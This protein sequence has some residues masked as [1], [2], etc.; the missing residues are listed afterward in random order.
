L[1]RYAR[2][3][4]PVRPGDDE[5]R[6]QSLLDVE[7]DLDAAVL[8]RLGT[9]LG[10]H[11]A[12]PH[13]CFFGLLDGYAQ[14]HGSPAVSLFT[15]GGGGRAGHEPEP[16]LPPAFPPPVL[17]GPRVSLPA[18]DYL[19]FRGP[20]SLAGEW[21]GMDLAPGQP[22]AINSPNRLWPADRAFFVATEIDLPWTG[23]AGSEPLIRDLIADA[24]LD[25]EQID[26]ARHPPYWRKSGAHP[27]A[28]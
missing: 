17:Q 27:S 16:A 15:F 26:L 4:H 14:I 20:L 18:R 25:I 11:A 8:R 13:D 23:I 22:R 5:T 28:Q 19:L 6:P 1:E 10:R 2:L 3:F 7:G 12:M 24:G 21:G 9:V